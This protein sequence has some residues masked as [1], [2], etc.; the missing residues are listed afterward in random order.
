MTIAN[1]PSESHNKKLTSKNILLVVLVGIGACLLCICLAL[2]I[3]RLV[4]WLKDT[5]SF[6]TLPFV[7]NTPSQT[8]EPP[9][10]NPVAVTPSPSPTVTPQPS[11]TPTPTLGIGS[12]EVRPNDGMVMVYVP[13]AEFTM[14]SD[15]GD[16]NESP[17]HNVALDDFW[18]DQTEVTNAMFQTFV[19]A[20]G[21]RTSAEEIGQSRAYQPGEYT[22]VAEKWLLVGGANWMH[23]QGPGT[24]IES[25]ENHPVVQVSWNDAVAY[26]LWAGARLP[27]EAEWELS[28][29]GTD[30]R[31]YPWGNSWPTGEL[32]NLGDLNLDAIWSDKSTN[33]GY[34]F[35]APVGNYP[36]GRSPYGALDMAGNVAEWTADRYGYNFYAASPF[37]NPTG[38]ATGT[39]H[40]IRG[41]HWS[42]TA[43]GVRSTARLSGQQ[44]YSIDYLGFR[45]AR[46]P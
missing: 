17:P 35:T 12:T 13:A 4:L 10:A 37:S 3:T 18:I 26:C 15:T 16:T 41:G 45:C 32:L 33:D 11:I 29:R 34:K 25:L 28:A 30:G 31:I 14:G 38:P 24:G 27:T 42:F 44:T 36:A 1:H 7:G 19:T 39:L 20:T 40:S 21:Y 6:P 5:P 43:D 22:P 23:P 8:A 46:T 2:G 9:A